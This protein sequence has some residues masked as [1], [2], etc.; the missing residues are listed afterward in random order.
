MVRELG[1]GG[2]ERDL[3]KLAMRL[4][5][6]HFKPHVGCLREQGMRA[7]ELR[8]AGI[9]IVRFP[10]TSF[11]SP[12]F[13][14]GIFAFRRYVHDHGIRLLQTFDVPTNIF[15]IA[16]ARISGLRPAIAT[17]LWFLD[18]IPRQ[19]WSLHRLSMR[20][21]DVVVVNSEAVQRELLERG[22][23]KPSRIYVSHN[24][25]ETNVFNPQ[26]KPA[27]DMKSEVGL[28]VGAVCALRRE[29]RLD[30]MLDAFSRVKN[31]VPGV[32][33]VLVGSG[34]M[35][36]HLEQLRE[37]L[38]IA[39]DCRFE[40]ARANVAPWMR[41]M[42]VF[43]MCSESES[44]PNALLEAMACGC[45]VIGSNV[46]GIPELI[47]AGESGLLFRSG[48]AAD[49][50]EKLACVLKDAALRHRLAAAAAARAS[51]EFS[52]ET[53]AERMQRLYGSLLTA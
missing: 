20:F 44:F 10:V 3:T 33:L 34:E 11:R 46:G 30:V 16:A 25:V 49:L 53:A 31:D 48:D 4:D 13:L 35:L 18:T 28:V 29:K 26:V 38:G 36:P 42:D 1:I 19:L 39:R 15:G 23:V 24:G 41:S 37:R 32:K 45:C 27:C 9:P 7:D 22:H 40:P 50:A 12:S 5:R 6:S 51:S 21:A 17:Q 8:E 47:Q 43:V 2:S 52:M 14:R